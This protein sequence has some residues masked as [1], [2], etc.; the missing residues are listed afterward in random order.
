[1]ISLC[2]CVHLTSRTSYLYSR[3]PFLFHLPHGLTLTQTQKCVT[4]VLPGLTRIHKLISG[5]SYFIPSGPL[6]GLTRTH[7]DRLLYGQ[8]FED[9]NCFPSV[10]SHRLHFTHSPSISLSPV[11]RPRTS[12]P[13]VKKKKKKST[14]SS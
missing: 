2:L 9:Q 8:C 6:L 3:F 10:R 5:S 11:V 4:L 14:F 12:V 1:M 13:S 7:I